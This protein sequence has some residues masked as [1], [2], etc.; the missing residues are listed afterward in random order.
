MKAKAKAGNRTASDVMAWYNRA[1]GEDEVESEFDRWI[2]R[3]NSIGRSM[4]AL[5]HRQPRIIR[6]AAVE[7]PALEALLDEQ[8]RE[9]MNRLGWDYSGP[10]SLLREVVKERE[11]SGFAAVVADRLAGFSFYVID[12][13]R[14]SVGDIYVSAECR[15]QDVD[16]RIA[17]AIVDEM[18]RI[19]KLRRIEC[20]GVNFGNPGADEVFRNRG[21]IRVDRYFMAMAVQD[22]RRRGGA[23]PRGDSI[24][25]EDIEIRPWKEADFGRAARIIH[26][27]YQN[28]DDS[29]INSQYK[30]EE[31][32]GDLLSILTD[33]FWCGQ[34][35][36][37][38]SRI[39]VSRK[40][41]HPIGVLIAS[42]ISAGV[43]HIGQISILPSYQ[44]RGLG[45]R[46][47]DSVL[48]EFSNQQLNTATLAVTATNTRAIRLYSL[49]GFIRI[50]TFP[51]YY[52]EK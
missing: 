35:L 50:H 10:S 23:H 15:H 28:E 37:Q 20:Q 30:T 8:C 47:V 36:P 29:A 48:V 26:G 2:P 12:G 49:C 27:S 52:W 17:S 16:G 5:P 31:G 11:V 7:L 34:F 44:G 33:S 24:P 39:A 3:Q 25:G 32:C 21:L 42:R 18:D 22:P 45:R 13:N 51:V 40:K 6:L 4:S 41:G 19:P 38:A 46:L 9:S 14:C 1:M 43:G